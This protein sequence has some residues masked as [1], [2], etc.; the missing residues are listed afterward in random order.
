MFKYTPTFEGELQYRNVKYERISD[1][2]SNQIIA[3]VSSEDYNMDAVKLEKAP[4]I[5][6]Y[7]H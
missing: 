1:A 2:T 6:V 5:A 3:K 7:S 4:K